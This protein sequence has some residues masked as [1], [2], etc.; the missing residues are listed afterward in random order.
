MVCRELRVESLSHDSPSDRQDGRRERNGAPQRER[1]DRALPKG[2]T[3]HRGVGIRA[4]HNTCV[5]DED[6]AAAVPGVEGF[7]EAGDGVRVTQ[8]ELE[9]GDGAEG[10]GRQVLPK[11][12]DDLFAGLQVS[13]RGYHRGAALGESQG[14]VAADGTVPAGDDRH[15]AA[16]TTTADGGTAG[17][18]N[19]HHRHRG[20]SAGASSGDGGRI[21]RKT[22][23]HASGTETKGSP[24]EAVPRRCVKQPPQQPRRDDSAERDECGGVPRPGASDT[25]HTKHRRNQG[26]HAQKQTARLL[27]TKQQLAK[28]PRPKQQAKH[29]AKRKREATR[30]HD[31]ARAVL[32]FA[33]AYRYVICTVI[34]GKPIRTLNPPPP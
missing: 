22:A 1:P 14:N 33:G 9:R 26:R 25:V 6:V 13:A 3:Y 31:G 15:P 5:Q 28:Q 17:A 29:G 34:S 12:G 19:R 30:P 11:L 18:A 21:S 27:Q 23:T 20:M 24:D 2:P 7:G 10:V 8:V 32:G 4:H 16:K